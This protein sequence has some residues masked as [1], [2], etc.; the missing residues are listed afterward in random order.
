VA[1]DLV[2]GLNAMLEK[3]FDLDALLNAVT[4][5][6]AYSEAAVVTAA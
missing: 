3:P 2:T 6:L 1:D 5:C 4:G